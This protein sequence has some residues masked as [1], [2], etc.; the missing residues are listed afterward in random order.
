[1][2][3]GDGGVFEE[4]VARAVGDLPGAQGGQRDLRV[5]QAVDAAACRHKL[6]VA[7]R[8]AEQRIGEA[9][10]AEFT[11]GRNLHVPCASPE[12]VVDRAAQLRA[13]QPVRDERGDDDRRRHGDGRGEGEA[14]AERHSSRRT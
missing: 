7:A 12:R 4:R 13:N 3:V 10:V 1:V 2:R 9:E 8:A 14:C 5:G 6:G 11:A